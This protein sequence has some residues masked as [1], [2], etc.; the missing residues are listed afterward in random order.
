MLQVARMAGL[1]EHADD[2]RPSINGMVRQR[3]ST[4]RNGSAVDRGSRFRRRQVAARASRRRRR[5][6][7]HRCGGFGECRL[8]AP[9]GLD[10]SSDLDAAS[11]ALASEHVDH[12]LGLI[13][14]S[15]RKSGWCAEVGEGCRARQQLRR[16]ALVGSAGRL[17]QRHRLHRA[18]DPVA[19]GDAGS[20]SPGAASAGES[21]EHVERSRR[22]WRGLGSWRWSATRRPLRPSLLLRG[23]DPVTTDPSI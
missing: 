13:E 9:V 14:V 20:C 21:D 2:R 18:A 5:F 16:S 11:A 17:R 6:G 23:R 8:E 12:G 19:G 22:H 4:G 1:V 7:R 10:L 3:A 15:L